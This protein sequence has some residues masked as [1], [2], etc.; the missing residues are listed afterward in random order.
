MSV[1]N[2]TGGRVTGVDLL[3]V[4]SGGT[5]K[6][7][8]AARP[9]G[10]NALSKR[11]ELRKVFGAPGKPGVLGDVISSTEAVNVIADRD[12]H[13]VGEGAVSADVSYYAE[14]GITVVTNGTD[15]DAIIIAPHLDANQTSWAQT[16]WGTDEEV[17][18]ECDIRTGATITT[19][20]IW[21]G[22]KLTNTHA[23]ATDD[24]QIYFRYE[25]GVNSGGWEVV[26]SLAGI[27]LQEDA[28]VAVVAIN[29]RYHFK[30]TVDP[31]RIARMYINGVLV[32]T[33]AAL[34]TNIDFIPYIGIIES[35]ASAA[36]TL[37]VSGQAI[38]RRYR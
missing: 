15:A 5:V 16:T 18:W 31:D 19:T 10:L 28:G 1:V 6:L 35:G 11:Y 36:M 33:T 26:H 38:S 27:D 4:V 30:I 17:E 12:F 8:G 20:V 34:T 21:C 22:L 32:K 13:V 3:E 25:N 37:H 14:G 23:V 29:T 24:N 7:F 2:I 9:V